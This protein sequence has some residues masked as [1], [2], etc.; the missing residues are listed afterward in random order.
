MSAQLAAHIRVSGSFL[1]GAN[2]FILQKFNPFLPKFLAARGGG[3]ACVLVLSLE[4]PNSV[5]PSFNFCPAKHPFLSCQAN[6]STR[7]IRL[8]PQTPTAIFTGSRTHSAA[9]SPLPPHPGLRAR[10]L[11]FNNRF[12]NLSFC[13][14]FGSDWHHCSCPPLLT[15]HSVL[16]T[17]VAIAD[18][19]NNS[20][21][22]LES[23]KGDKSTVLDI[24]YGY[25]LVSTCHFQCRAL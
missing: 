12:Y 5:L 17:I 14:T 20:Y 9:T 10:A 15:L 6:F 22:Q 24:D 4:L 19:S 18:S 13:T 21:N 2:N 25:K 8:W 23:W 1:R 11:H 3:A 16:Y 7:Q